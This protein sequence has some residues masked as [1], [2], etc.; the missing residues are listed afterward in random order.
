[1]TLSHFPLWLHQAVKIAPKDKD[2][3]AKYKECEKAYKEARWSDAIAVDYQASSPFNT[4]GD[5]DAIGNSHLVVNTLGHTGSLTS[6][7]QWWTATMMDLT[8]RVR[9]PSILSCR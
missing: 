3:R 7:M 8:C 5:I 6:H 2:C 1:M 9:S 4:I